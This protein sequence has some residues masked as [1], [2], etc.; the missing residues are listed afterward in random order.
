MFRLGAYAPALAYAGSCFSQLADKQDP[1]AR[2]LGGDSAHLEG[3][4]P[5]FNRAEGSTEEACVEALVAGARA[6]AAGTHSQS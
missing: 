3:P 4:P 1:L 6:E 2:V 5:Q